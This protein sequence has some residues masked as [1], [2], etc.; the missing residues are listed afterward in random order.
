VDASAIALLYA[1]LLREAPTLGAWVGQAAAL[2]ESEGAAAGI[3]LLDTLDR[4]RAELY[5]PYWAVRAHLLGQLGNAAEAHEAYGRALML[6]R[7]DAVCA[8]LRERRPRLGHG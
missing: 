5:Q 7:D 8:F 6:T 4:A 1:G 3:A 2:A